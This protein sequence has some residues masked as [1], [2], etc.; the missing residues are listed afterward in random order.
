VIFNCKHFARSIDDL[1]G[2]QFN[3]RSGRDSVC[4]LQRRTVTSYCRAICLLELL[5]LKSGFLLVTGIVFFARDIGNVMRDMCN[6]WRCSFSHFFFFLN[7]YFSFTFV[8]Y[9]V[10]DFITIIVVD[11]CTG[12][13]TA[14]NRQRRFSGAGFWRRFHDCVCH[15]FNN[16]SP[17]WRAGPT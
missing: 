13:G 9:L 6:D 17:S 2:D 12:M 15:P 10:C 14:R 3:A 4:K 8:V 7:V 16:R 1:M 11:S 5:I